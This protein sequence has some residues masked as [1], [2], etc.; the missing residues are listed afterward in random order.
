MN[1]LAK[2]PAAAAEKLQ[3][4]QNKFLKKKK[5]KARQLKHRRSISKSG[6]SSRN[7]NSIRGSNHGSASSSRRRKSNKKSTS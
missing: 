4:I 2:V 6:S 7:I 5:V 3:K 1:I